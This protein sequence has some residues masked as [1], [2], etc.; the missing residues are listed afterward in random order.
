MQPAATADVWKSHFLQTIHTHIFFMFIINYHPQPSLNQVKPLEGFLKKVVT[1]C[2]LEIKSECNYLQTIS[3]LSPIEN[4]TKMPLRK[5]LNEHTLLKVRVSSS[6]LH[7]IIKRLRAFTE[8]S[9]FKQQTILKGRVQVAM[10]AL[11]PQAAQAW[12]FTGN[13]CITQ[14]HFWKSLSVKEVHP[15]MQIKTWPCK[16][17]TH[18]QDIER[19]F[20]FSGPDLIKYELKWHGELYRGL[21]LFGKYGCRT[22][23]AKRR[24]DP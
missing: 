16:E 19:P 3:I 22:V 14:D 15:Q 13:L 1:Q 23:Q 20:V 17:K 11:G 6:S 10:W 2:K 4:G 21:W 9:P 12:C 8:I 24:E 18:K 7:N 5:R